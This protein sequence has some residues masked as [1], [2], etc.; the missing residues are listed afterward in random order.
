[1]PLSLILLDS[2]NKQKASDICTSYIRRER[3]VKQMTCDLIHPLVERRVLCF[4]HI[5]ALLSNHIHG[6]LD[7]TIGDDWEHR[8][9]DDTEVLDAM[10][11][12]LAVN[13]TLVDTLREAGSSTRI[14]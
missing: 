14:W 13:H 3:R 5:C 12:Q 7:S 10:D 9:I 2:L 1:M 4:D 8:C 11:L 6:I